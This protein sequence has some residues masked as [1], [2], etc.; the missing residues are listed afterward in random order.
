M[1]RFIYREIMSTFLLLFIELHSE[2]EW[3]LH[4]GLWICLFL[5]SLILTIQALNN[6]AEELAFSKILFGIVKSRTDPK[7]ASQLYVQFL[8]V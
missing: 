6:D 2:T 4:Q 5:N 1:Y 3:K 8:T 7:H